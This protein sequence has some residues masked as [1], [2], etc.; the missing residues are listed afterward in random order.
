M[1]N[2][3]LST[4]HSLITNEEL[5]ETQKILQEEIN[6]LKQV[7]TNNYSDACSSMNLPFDEGAIK[8][9]KELIVEKKT[10]HP[11]Y[12][13][14]VGIGGSNLGTIAVHEAIQGK[15]YNAQNP[16]LKV[17]FADTVDPDLLF[18]ILTLITPV[19]ENGENIIINAV[20]KSGGT[21]ETI[22]I[23]EIL[24]KV[25]QKYKKNYEQYVVVTTDFESPFWHLAKEKGFSTL[26]IPK[27]V[28]GRYSVFSAVGLFPLGMLDVNIDELVYGAQQMRDQCLEQT[29][30]HN[31][32][33][34][35][36]A[37]IYL[38]RKKGIFMHDLFLFSTDL[39]SMG[40]WYRQLM[41]ESLGKEYDRDGNQI[42]S[43]ITPTISI[44]STDLHSMA[45]LYLGGP[46]DKF[47]TFIRIKT[48]D[49]TITLPDFPEYSRLVRNIQN[50]SLQHIMDAILLGI[51]RAF[52]KGKR[53]FMQ[54]LLSNKSPETI[55]QLLQF[56]EMEMMYLGFLLNVNP[57]DQPSV[58]DYKIETKKILEKESG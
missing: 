1:K 17:L 34:L 35:S 24:I 12:L 36:A 18:N 10:L 22:A 44:G 43:G 26:E 37:L 8:R 52:I 53:P 31:P 28:G 51:Q 11:R 42:F 27:I 48:T 23:F 55:G 2:I 4:D 29:F 19:L 50:N 45:Q 32:A 7:T 57:F 6:H 38:H 46:Y 54:I 16:A 56:K 58:E 13:I 33:A 15:F 14:V 3:S 39:E 49:N 21:T 20:S 47:T 9:I 5:H 40:K 25:L 30:E 41:G